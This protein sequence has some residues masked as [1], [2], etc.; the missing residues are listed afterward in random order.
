[1]KDLMNILSEE[2]NRSTLMIVSGED[3]MEFARTL[4]NYA[5]DE[6][7]EQTEPTYYTRNELSEKLHVSSVTLY[8]YEKLGLIT[9]KKING[10]N[11]YDKKSV[12]ELMNKKMRRS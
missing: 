12:L 10:K 2:S 4:I 8:R 5:K 11:L 6:I 9:G 3:L 7:K 1:M